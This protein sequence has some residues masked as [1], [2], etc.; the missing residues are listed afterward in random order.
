MIPLIHYIG[1]TAVFM[2][3]MFWTSVGIVTHL[4]LQNGWRRFYVPDAWALVGFVASAL[5]LGWISF[6]ITYGLYR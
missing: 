1:V 2:A 6:A 4:N 5:A 3:V